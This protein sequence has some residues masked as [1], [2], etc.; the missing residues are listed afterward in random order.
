TAYVLK[1]F[2]RRIT[3]RSAPLFYEKVKGILCS[4]SEKVLIENLNEF[5]VGYALVQGVNPLDVDPLVPEE[6]LLPLTNHRRPRTPDFAVQL[7]EERVFFEATVLHIQI[8]DDWD[9]SVN[10]ITMALKNHLK[11][12]GKDLTIHIQFPL[13]F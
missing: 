6:F 10:D 5:Q 8:L 9:K 3:S 7:S 2:Q 4:E 11:K 1:L 13:P 12:R